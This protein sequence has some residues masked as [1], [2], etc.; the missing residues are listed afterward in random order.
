MDWEKGRESE[1]LEDRRGLSPKTMAVGG[2]IG[3]LL[4]M[5]VGLVLGVPQDQLNKLFNQG[6][7]PGAEQG[8]GK[9]RELTPEEKQS[10]KFYRAVLAFTEDVWTDQFKK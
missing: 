5:I 6:Q 8:D 4:I 3:A 9:E 7:P 10:Q 2:G 1:N